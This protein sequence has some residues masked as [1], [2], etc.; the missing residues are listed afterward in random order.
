MTPDEEDKIT[1]RSIIDRRGVEFVKDVL[2]EEQDNILTIVSNSGVHPVPQE[3][4]FGELYIASTGTLDF[5]NVRTVN[6]E[7]DNI[8]KALHRKLVEKKW[9][10]IYVIPFGHS[11]ISMNIKLAVYRTLRIETTD[12]FYFG[13]GEYGVLD[14]EMRPLLAGG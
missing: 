3:F 8:I 13:G 10:K 5:S 6:A 12:V 2:A 11:V 14:R 9:K 4:V 7:I 1:L